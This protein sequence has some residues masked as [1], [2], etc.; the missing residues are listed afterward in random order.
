V[1]DDRHPHDL[2]HEGHMD[3]ILRKA[4]RLGLDPVTALRMVTL[5]PAEHFGLHDAGGIAPGYRADLVVLEDLECFR[6]EWLIHGG[7][8]IVEDGIVHESAFR[9][10][11]PRLANSV[12]VPMIQ[13]EG[14][15]LVARSH[16][17]R[18]IEL[19]PGPSNPSLWTRD[20]LCPTAGGTS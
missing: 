16:R 15:R 13:P 12:H 8:V 9:R 18:V 14:L 10:E 17:V 6:V 20:S 5:N 4:I 2:S 11:T 19:I 7:K 3:A 1:S